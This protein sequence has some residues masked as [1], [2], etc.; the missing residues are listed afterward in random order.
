MFLLM[1]ILF[2]MQKY[3]IKNPVM[4]RK[5]T[6]GN[7]ER[8]I[9]NI[10]Q[11]ELEIKNFGKNWENKILLDI[12]EDDAIS[13]NYKLELLKDDSIKVSNITAGGL[14]NDFI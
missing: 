9:K 11:Y 13:I 1:V 14:T 4:L 8:H 12:L 10:T 2:Y 7:D 3:I 5:K 6:S